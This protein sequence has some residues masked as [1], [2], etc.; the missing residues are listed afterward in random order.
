MGEDLAWANEKDQSLR[1]DARARAKKGWSYYRLS[2]HISVSAC[3]LENMSNNAAK[4][5]STLMTSGLAARVRKSRGTR[6][7]CWRQQNGSGEP[8]VH[9]FGGQR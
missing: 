6:V 5:V 1:V 3:L 8:R 9:L 2:H 4:S 7:V